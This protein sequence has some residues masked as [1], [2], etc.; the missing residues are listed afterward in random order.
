M[1]ISK[2][3][4]AASEI[5][6]AVNAL[7]QQPEHPTWR[8]RYEWL[9]AS[10]T[11]LHQEAQNLYEDMQQNGLKFSSI[12]AEG[13]LRAMKTVVNE[14]K[15]IDEHF[16]LNDIAEGEVQAPE[17]AI[18]VQAPQVESNLGIYNKVVDV[19]TR[20]I[21]EL[22][23]EKFDEQ[24]AVGAIMT[25]LSALGFDEVDAVELMLNIEDA[26]GIE[27]DSE[28]EKQHPQLLETTAQD[29]ISFVTQKLS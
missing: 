26:L 18:P 1:S 16:V 5:L 11:G 3:K 2:I 27:L 20:G 8:E 12:E 22:L 23:I 10:I 21:N 25:P 13:Y 28:F 7:D 6:D 24:F 4:A 29:F 14:I 9:C 17:V 19:V 15:R